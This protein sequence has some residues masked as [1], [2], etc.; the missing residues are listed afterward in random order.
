MIVDGRSVP[1]AG[2]LPL[3]AILRSEQRSP[4]P[5]RRVLSRESWLGGEGT[6]LR[7]YRSGRWILRPAEDPHDCSVL[8]GTLT[9][10]Q[11]MYFR[12]RAIG[13]LIHFHLA[14]FPRVISAFADVPRSPF[15]L[16][17]PSN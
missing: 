7:G 5:V 4:V 12:K 6:E 10:Q 14:S 1:G 16:P 2:I 8:S 3:D 9:G 17:R 11:D 15:P 13:S